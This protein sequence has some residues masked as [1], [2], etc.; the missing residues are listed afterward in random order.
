MSPSPPSPMVV[1]WPR[2]W[3]QPVGVGHKNG[4]GNGMANGRGCGV[5]GCGRFA[6]CG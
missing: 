1:K 3:A 2:F 4:I 6:V 5:C